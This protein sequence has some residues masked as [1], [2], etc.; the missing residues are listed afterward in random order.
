MV[1]Y[2]LT[3]GILALVLIAAGV[4]D[5]MLR[6]E[7]TEVMG[8]LGYPP[9]LAPLLGVA[10][11]LAAVAILAPG[12]PRLKEWAYAGIVIDLGG[13]MYSHIGAG[14]PEQIVTP[15]LLLLVAFTSWY[16]RPANRKLLDPIDIK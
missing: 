12:F 1:G 4:M 13:A 3:T 5:L 2:W 6:P 16:L 15:V 9:Y 11:L 14:E 7:I 10:K 8:R